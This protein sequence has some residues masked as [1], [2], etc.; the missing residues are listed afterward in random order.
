MTKQLML[1]RHGKSDWSAD[2]Q[3]DLDRPLAKRGKKAARAV[4]MF[5]DKTGQTPELI[6]QSP[7]RRASQTLAHAIE[8]GGW[9][10]SCRV[11]HALYEG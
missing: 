9:S 11:M 7:A 6:L 1:L 2:Y 10:C 3:L 4:G 8:A 5:L